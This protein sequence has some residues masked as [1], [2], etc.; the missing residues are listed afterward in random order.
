MR[1]IM[2]TIKP[3]E[4]NRL[5]ADTQ[6]RSFRISERYP[7]IRRLCA[8]ALLPA[9]IFSGCGAAAGEDQSGKTQASGTSDAENADKSSVETGSTGTGSSEDTALVTTGTGADDDPMEWSGMYFDTVISIR[10]YGD[11]A[12]E[13]M[14]GCADLCSHM[15][16]TLSAQKETSELYQVNHRTEQTVTVSDDLAACIE[17]GLKYSEMSDGAFDITILPVKDLWDFEDSSHE[18]TVPDDKDIQEQ[19]K[20]VDYTKVHL[21]GNE[22]SFDSPDTMLDLGGIAKGYISGKLK[23]Y[24]T[25]EGCQSALINLGGNVRAIGTKP[26]GTDWTVGIQT[27]FDDRGTVLTTVS[28]ADDSVISS[29]IY[30]RYFKKDGKIYHHILDPRTGYPAET[31]LNQVTVLGED[32]AAGDA[33]ATIGIVLGQEGMKDFLQKNHLTDTETVLFTDKD[34]AYTWYPSAPE[35]TE[36]EQ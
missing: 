19:L 15:E 18:G 14:Q 21:D 29:G 31:D 20:K 23:D 28:T 27:P 10:L 7:F 33:L 30:E 1:D 3:G 11:K 13:W 24:L 26:D 22:L 32:D 35:G 12:A 6:E 16:N 25:K 4:Q 9:V 2:N 36:D 34:N 8:M 5:S 17:E